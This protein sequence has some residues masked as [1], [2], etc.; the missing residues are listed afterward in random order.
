MH[1]LYFRDIDSLIALTEVLK[2]TSMPV[3]MEE[4]EWTERFP[5]MKTHSIKQVK[6]LAVSNPK[7]ILSTKVTRSGRPVIHKKL[8]S[9]EVSD[10]TE[11][12]LEEPPRQVFTAVAPMVVNQ[13]EIIETSEPEPV[14]METE[15]DAKDVGSSVIEG[16]DTMTLV[17]ECCLC[18]KRVL[19][20]NSLGRHMKNN[21]P[22]GLGPYKCPMCN[23]MFEAGVKVLKHMSSH[24]KRDQSYPKETT[25][26][27]SRE[28]AAKKKPEKSSN[29]ACNISHDHPQ[30]QCKESFKTATKFVE[31]MRSVHGLKAA[32]LCIQCEESK[33]FSERQNYQY[34]LMTHDGKRGFV[35]DICSKSF[36]NPRQLYSHRSLHLGKRYLC[37][38]CGF[39][40]RSTANLRGH[41][42]TK[43]EE[44]GF[45]CEVCSKKFSSNTNLKNHLR[46][47]TNETPYHCTLCNVKFKRLH[48]LNSHLASKVHQVAIAECKRK[49]VE[50]PTRLDPTK[51]N[52]GKSLVEDGPV[53]DEPILLGHVP[54]GNM[55][56]IDETHPYVMLDDGS[57]VEII[58]TE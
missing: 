33:R 53:T 48:H 39:R 47:H 45:S 4:K 8:A 1:P 58:H 56:V 20:R 44:K 29:F 30:I 36:A 2:L 9:D 6:T 19:G 3:V 10:F 37:P 14:P 46:I 42:K 27:V 25:S 54:F 24:M 5:L 38:H 43:H 31:H 52:R 34:H 18:Q 26:K 40:A 49:G 57:T 28:L 15:I 13:V 12:A 50:I 11:E 7:P 41:I 17:R 21:H 32:W 55:V 16:T 23:K 51:R 35:C 22:S